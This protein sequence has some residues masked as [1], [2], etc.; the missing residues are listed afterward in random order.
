M[1]IYIIGMKK[2]MLWVVFTVSFMALFF[3]P[4]KIDIWFF[5]QKVI[6]CALVA[7]SAIRLQ[8]DFPEDEEV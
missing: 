8:R 7:W 3:L 4:S 5:V 2:A 1:Q 6:A